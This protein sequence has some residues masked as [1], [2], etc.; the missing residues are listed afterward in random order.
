MANICQK[1][2]WIS[3]I[4]R[5]VYNIITQIILVKDRSKFLLI[6]KQKQRLNLL[7]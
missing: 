2:M 1:I 3:I 6:D 4:S 5:S 7:V